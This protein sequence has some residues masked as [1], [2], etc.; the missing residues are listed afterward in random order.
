MD[1]I[2]RVNKIKIDEV[3]RYSIDG[4]TEWLQ[5]ILVEL[6]ED[7]GHN[8]EDINDSFIEFKASLDKEHYDEYGEVLFLEG[9]VRVKY[10]DISVQ[11]GDQITQELE[12]PVNCVFLNQ[13]NEKKHQ[14]EEEISIFFGEQ[15]WDLY[16]YKN[17]QADL[18]PVIHEYVF[19]NKNPYPG[20]P[21]E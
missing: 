1:Q 3:K 17:N 13:H 19:L 9:E 5:T 18:L 12:I 7:T 16:Y 11:T 8:K 21:N 20:K 15:D 10:L 2:Q 6:L 14:L 4:K